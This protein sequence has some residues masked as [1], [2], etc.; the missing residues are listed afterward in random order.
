M[1]PTP[2]PIRGSGH[3]ESTSTTG[4]TAT[5]SAALNPTV[6]LIVGMSRVNMLRTASM[7]QP[8]GAEAFFHEHHAAQQQRDLQ[9][10]QGDHPKPRVARGHPKQNTCLR[11]ACPGQRQPTQVQ[12]GRLPQIRGVQARHR[13]VQMQVA[14]N[15]PGQLL[16]GLTAREDQPRITG[17]RLGGRNWSAAL[18]ITRFNGSEQPG[19]VGHS[20]QCRQ[21]VTG[22]R[23]SGNRGQGA[24][25]RPAPAVAETLL[26]GCFSP[27]PGPETCGSA[28]YCCTDAC[29][30]N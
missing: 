12:P 5:T 20:G 4:L 3:W 11:P 24:T 1:P 18:H 10:P 8:A 29:C 30:I 13:P 19:D 23:A 27:P 7:P 9:S 17:R 25:E 28:P 16:V 15:Q 2:R 26:D 6:P 14:A 22:R 21:P